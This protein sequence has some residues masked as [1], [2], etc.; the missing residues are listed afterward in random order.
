MK[1]LKELFLQHQL[2]EVDEKY[3]HLAAYLLG[4][5]FIAENEEALQNS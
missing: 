2:I 4:N 1:S 5:V 3:K